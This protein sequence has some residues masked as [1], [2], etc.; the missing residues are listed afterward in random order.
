[1]NFIIVAFNNHAGLN[2]EIDAYVASTDLICWMD[3][4]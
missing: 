1:M 3:L 2:E 4:L